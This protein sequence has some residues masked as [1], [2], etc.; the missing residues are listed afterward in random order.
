LVSFTLSVRVSL[1][2]IFLVTFFQERYWGINLKGLHCHLSVGVK[3][4]KIRIKQFALSTIL[5]ITLL[6]L[7]SVEFVQA[8]T[9]TL[10]LDQA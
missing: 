8:Q 10:V 6:S 2:N 3:L 5:C 9:I 4:D 7:V 1:K